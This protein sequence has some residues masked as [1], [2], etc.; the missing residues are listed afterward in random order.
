MTSG[1]DVSI[2]STQFTS[3]WNSHQQKSLQPHPSDP[4]VTIDKIMDIS[5]CGSLFT[6]ACNGD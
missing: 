6:V 1:C 4:T 3:L 5:Q 2:D